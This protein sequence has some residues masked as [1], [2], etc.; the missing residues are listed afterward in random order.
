MKF[1]KTNK[2]N[3]IKEDKRINQQEGEYSTNFRSILSF[4]LELIKIVIISLAIIIPIRAYVAQ[5]FYVE[6]AS[7]EPNFYDKEY[8]IVDEISYRFTA[9]ARDEVVIFRPPNNYNQYY[10]KRIIGLPNETVEIKNNQI[11]ITNAENPDGFILDESKYLANE[12]FLPTEQYKVTLENDQYY[13]LGDNRRNSLD[14][15]RFGPINF[16]NIKGRV[17]L[18]AFPFDRFTFFTE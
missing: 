9:P 13:V 7:M 3:E 1:L 8:L 4:F 10:I 16:A 14:S 11:K 6:G 5:P 2:E 18:R 12:S 15:R 17:F